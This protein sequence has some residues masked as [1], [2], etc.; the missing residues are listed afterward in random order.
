MNDVEILVGMIPNL[1]IYLSCSP[2]DRFVSPFIEQLSI[3][4]IRNILVFNYI[5][6][7]WSVIVLY[8]SLIPLMIAFRMK[9]VKDIN[10]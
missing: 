2:V 7:V 5:L 4:L 1:N 3:G 8:F 10:N 6:S 9:Y